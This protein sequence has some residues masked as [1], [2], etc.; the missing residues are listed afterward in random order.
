MFK[1]CTE[2]IIS[3]G[4]VCFNID[5]N[6]GINNKCIEN[7]FYNKFLDINEFNYMN[8]NNISMIPEYY[9]KIRFLMIRRKQSLNYIEFIRGKYDINN[10]IISIFELM[11]IPELEKIKSCSFDSL[12]NCLWN[13]TAKSKMYMKEYNMA[14]EKFETL[15]KNN[16]YNLLDD[17]T[18]F[19]YTEPEWG[20][21]KGRRNINENNLDCAI[22]EFSEETHINMNNLMILERL[23]P[24]EEDFIGTNMKLYKHTYYLANCF[25]EINVSAEDVQ[26]NEIG[27]IG[28]YTIPEVIEKMRPYHDKRIKMIHMIYFFIINLISD[29]TKGGSV[30]SI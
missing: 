26:L 29:I 11:S 25:N 7:Y 5:A 21:P 24:L 9:D 1:L 6:L 4:I 12:W 22:R 2:P 27:D 14:K 28:W 15:K 18:V 20:F 3:Y 10:N 13:E 19:R 30:L 17:M 16:F 8:L 23:N